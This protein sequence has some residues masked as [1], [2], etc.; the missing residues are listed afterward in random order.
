MTDKKSSL[1]SFFIY[2]STVL[3]SVIKVLL[4]GFP[5]GANLFESALNCRS[6]P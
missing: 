4:V 5:A 6:H 1:S 2:V 3:N